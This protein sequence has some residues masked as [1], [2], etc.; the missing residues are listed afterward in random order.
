MSLEIRLGELGADLLEEALPKYLA[1]ELSAVPQ[2]ESRAMWSHRLTTAESV[3]DFT[4]PVGRSSPTLISAP[5][6]APTQYWVRI[7]S[8]CGTVSSN[9]CPAVPVTL[10]FC[11]LAE[12][13]SSAYRTPARR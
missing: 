7:S 1:G 3:L 10:T 12:F 9:S 2:D 5:I 13:R 8:P 11:E 4:K 6:S